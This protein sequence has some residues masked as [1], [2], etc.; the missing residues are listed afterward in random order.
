MGEQWQVPDWRGLHTCFLC[1]IHVRSVDL[2]IKDVHTVL[3]LATLCGLTHVHTVFS[4]ITCTCR[5]SQFSQ[6]LSILVRMLLSVS[7][8]RILRGK[9]ETKS[10]PKTI[11]SGNGNGLK[12]F[13]FKYTRTKECPHSVCKTRLRVFV[14]E[15]PEPNV[16]NKL[17]AQRVRR[18]VIDT[19][20]NPGIF[21]NLK[22]NFFFSKFIYS[23][24]K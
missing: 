15:F 1:N 23:M 14:Y 18:H 6:K 11:F 16:F 3:E 2:R 9:T 8:W 4:R 10:A 13:Y 20:S 12:E 24:I 21:F 7:K 5:C 22:K 17:V 19:G